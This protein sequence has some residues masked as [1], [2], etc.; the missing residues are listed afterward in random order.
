MP[1][2]RFILPPDPLQ[3]LTVDDAASWQWIEAAI[4]KFRPP[5]V[6]I[7]ALSGA[8]RT[9][10]ISGNDEMKPIMKKLVGLAQKHNI[11]VVVIHHLNKPA[12]GMPSYPITIHRLL[13]AQAIPQYCRSILAIGTP[14]PSRPESRRLDVIKLN[15]AR[16]PKAIGYELTDHGPAFGEAPEPPKERRAVDDAVDFLEM[17][18]ANGPRPSEE[19]DGERKAAHIGGNA[20]GNAK[21]VLGVTSRR[22]GGKDGRWFL[23]PREKKTAGSQGEARAA[24]ND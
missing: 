6:V 12:P 20:L 4:E 8:H 10:K 23:F 13:G 7:D 16:K 19:I 21:N 11:A 3:E 5:L 15:L 2:G 1:R 17:A 9:G 18:L 24:E 22:E 14:D